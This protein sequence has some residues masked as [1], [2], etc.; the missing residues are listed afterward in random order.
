MVYGVVL[1]GGIGSRMGNVEKPKQ[2]LHIGNKPIIV[3]T[4][5]KFCVNNWIDKVVV[6]CPEQWVS[7]TK[8]LLKKYLGTMENVS[9]VPGGKTRNDTI[10]NAIA[11]IEENYGLDDET[12]VVT[13]DAVRPF[14]THRIIEDNIDAV[15]NGTA[16]DTVI[17]ATDTIVESLDN[18]VISQIPDRSKYYQGQTPQSFRAKKFKDLYNSLSEEEKK[19]LTDAA[20]VFV[21]KGERVTLVQGE[22]FNIKV[23]YP[24]DLQVAETLLGGEKK[25]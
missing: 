17:P 25:C 14:V 23:T 4:V 19:I 18:Q 5:E 1:A 12:I 6:L 10:M 3:H 21:I 20:K 13:H 9:I 15:Q 22:T 2:F 7:Y 24:Y 8:D 16:C 11:F